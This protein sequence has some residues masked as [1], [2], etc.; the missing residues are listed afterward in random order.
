[1]SEQVGRLSRRAAPKRPQDALSDVFPVPASVFRDRLYSALRRCGF[2]KPEVDQTTNTVTASRETSTSGHLV[3]RQ[4]ATLALVWGSAEDN[5]NHTAASWYVEDHSPGS[6]G[7]PDR[8]SMERVKALL[9]QEMVLPPWPPPDE[10]MIRNPILAPGQSPFER[11]YSG[12]LRDYSGCATPDEVLD[13]LQGVLPLG[14]YAFGQPGDVF[15]GPPLFLARDR[16]KAL[17]EHKGI[18]VCAPQNSGKTS[19][20]AKWAEAANQA[21]YNI[22]LVDVKR[23]LR[24]KFAQPLRGQVFTFSTDPGEPSDRINFLAGLDCTTPEGTERIQ[25]LVTAL[26]PSEGWTERGREEG[27]HYR[28]RV[29]WLTALVHILKLAELY[30]PDLYCE[31]DGTPRAAD[32]NDLYDLTVDEAL[33]Y[34]LIILLRECEAGRLADGQPLPHC[35]AD[36]WIR[37]A[38]HLLDPTRCP[39]RYLISEGALRRL[40]A[41]G[42]IEEILY[43]VVDLKDRTFATEGLFRDEL[44]RLL[45]ADELQAFEE[46]VFEEA[47][48]PSEG[49]REPNHGYRD[50]TQGMVTALEPFSRHGTLYD[51]ISGSGPGRLFTL[52]ELGRKCAEP[53]TILL[54][55]REQDLEKATTV[56]AL[57]IN[58]LQ[59]LLFDRMKEK[60][61][62]IPRVLLLLDETR[63]IRGFEAARY[64]TFAREARAGCVISYQ[65]L[66]QIGDEKKIMEVL[67]NVGTQIYLGSLVGNTARY[68]LSALPRRYRPTV[69]RQETRGGGVVA[70]SLVWSRELAD[71]L[72]AYDL[73]DLPG[74]E[75]PAMVYLNDLPRRKPFLVDLYDDS[76]AQQP[77]GPGGAPP[78]PGQPARR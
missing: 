42:A 44:A 68:F 47:A 1:M 17:M 53:V 74:G 57:V 33:L 8:G 59:H 10:D 66:D 25:A 19:L 64:I 20:I 2:D 77:R 65:A 11:A 56:L 73:Y 78:D 38:A 48:L 21:G 76:L 61:A 50:Y 15:Y 69:S 35:G 40:N 49:E 18:L 3:I 71:Y 27:F 23:N 37:E 16:T 14:R 39:L 62:E 72:A 4:K 41:A 6:T 45:T 12:E 32:L 70:T 28:N 58:R 34:D 7:Q 54:T 13:L 43:R 26:L 52:E 22:F 24:T 60:E 63:R 29:V 51:K 46:A 9:L 67:E 55:A 30:R 31:D 36:H 5:E 75:W